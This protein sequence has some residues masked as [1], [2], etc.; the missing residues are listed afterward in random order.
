MKAIWTGDEAE[1]HGRFVDFDA[2]WSWPKPAQKPH[3]PILVGG[4]GPGTIDRVLDYGDGWIPIGARMQ[5][6][7]GQLEELQKKA[8]DAGRGRIP[9]SIFGAVPKPEAIEQL[10]KAGAER[11]IFWLPPA[12]RDEVL[13]RL[14]RYAELL[15]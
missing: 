7:A 5:D 9:V 8:A 10:E 12:E 1:Y 4:G 3:P 13:P 14:D 6:L 15:A 11:A 2:I